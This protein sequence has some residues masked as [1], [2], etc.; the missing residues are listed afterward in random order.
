[1]SDKNDRELLEKYRVAP[2]K[3]CDLKKFDP[4]EKGNFKNKHE[5]KK[6]LEAEVEKL[7][8]LQEVL[9]AESKR[10]VLIVLQATDTGGKDGTIRYVL[11]P[12]NPQGVRVSSFKAPSP[13]ERAHDYLWRI[14][15]SVPAKGMIG[16]FNRSHYED[17][18]VVR[19][20]DLVPRA[21]IDRRYEQINQFEKYLSE[22]KVT[23][24][25]FYLHISKAEQKR[26]LEARL[27]RSDKHWKFSTGDLA[28]RKHWNEYQKTF[29]RTLGKCSTKHAPWYVIPANYKPY[30][31]VVIA[32]ILRKTMTDMKCE[33]PQPEAGLDKIVIPD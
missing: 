1:M 16:V 11:G 19:V 17:V 28:E 31:N 10:A 27:E 25:K 6:I 33:F 7:N 15:Q 21:E 20:H 23:I 24:L 30:R 8:E 3:S 18:I 2:G 32:R 9:Y 5:A 26:R 14:H 29:A 12:L 4:D 22:N 13:V